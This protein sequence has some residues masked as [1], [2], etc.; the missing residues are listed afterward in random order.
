MKWLLVFIVCLSAIP[1]FASRLL[2]VE[3]YYQRKTSDFI[4][5]RYPHRA[6]SV[7]IIVQAEE[8]PD[9]RQPASNRSGESISLPYLNQVT[10][11]SVG[12]WER[13]DLSL[14]TMISYLKGIFV[15]VE[16]EGQLSEIER[17]NFKKDL[18]KYLKLSEIYD[19]IEVKN[20]LWGERS[21]LWQEIKGGVL[22]ALASVLSLGF[23][24]FAIFHLGVG[25]LVNG[26]AKP[27]SEIGKSAE[28]VANS[29]GISTSS[30]PKSFVDLNSQNQKDILGEDKVNW[31][32]NEMKEL[33][34][35]FS[36]PNS[37][38]L[39]LLE[40]HGYEN[41]HA[42][43]SLLSLLSIETLKELL[44]WSQGS[45]WR[46]AVT[47]PSQLTTASMNVLSEIIHL[48]RRQD[49][50][51]EN[52]EKHR[53]L[54]L[55]LT[56]LNKKDFGTILKGYEFE[57]AEPILNLLPSDLKMS[58][59][60]YLYPGEW[61]RLLKANNQPLD[62]KMAQTI[63]SQSL[64]LAPRKSTEEINQYFKDAD[65]L[66]VLDHSNTKDEREIYRTLDQDS[67]IVKSLQ[68]FYAI[69]DSNESVLESL[70]LTIPLESWAMAITHCDREECDTL[71]KYFNSRQKYILRNF[72]EHFKKQKLASSFVAQ[73]KR[74]IVMR[75]AHQIE[76]NKNS[77]EEKVHEQAA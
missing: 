26:L 3:D 9:L 21:E 18:F 53:E 67:W 55:A 36:E 23:I 16:I 58:V 71:F 66:K 45:W 75:V 50:L 20:G 31:I 62:E 10:S 54:E 42:V 56:R 12:F 13:K 14:G 35:F 68:P 41:P 34:T 74:E 49:L 48:K 19:R 39:H 57:K 46:T 1:S 27:L 15:N 76:Q 32:E 38:L 65:L 40:K 33:S 47:Q 11:P 7:N 52:D 70:I 22:V 59:G 51:R 63:Q 61:A 28:S 69:F 77:A 17:E 44:V 6:F 24:L 37:Q 5:S 30:M 73:A 2:E 25:R 29:S 4:K 60:K 43:G 72:K 8:Q 64:K